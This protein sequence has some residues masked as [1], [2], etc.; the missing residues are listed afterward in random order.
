MKAVMERIMEGIRRPG[1]KRLGMIDDLII[2][3]LREG[4]RIV[5]I[6]EFGCQRPAVRPKTKEDE[7]L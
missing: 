3:T 1:K 5:K 6:R 2:E 7:V 4:P